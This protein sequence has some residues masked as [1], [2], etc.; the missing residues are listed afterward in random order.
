M[1]ELSTD[2]TVSEKVKCYNK[3]NITVTAPQTK[4]IRVAGGVGSTT[5]VAAKVFNIH[6]TANKETIV[7]KAKGTGAITVPNI[8]LAE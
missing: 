7:Y 1:P 3:A 2:N 5:N 6:N 4:H 8:T